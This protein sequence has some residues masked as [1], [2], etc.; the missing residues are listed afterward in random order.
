[1]LQLGPSGQWVAAHLKLRPAAVRLNAFPQGLHCPRHQAPL[2][3]INAALLQHKITHKIT[4]NNTSI[5]LRNSIKTLPCKW[6]MLLNSAGIHLAGSSKACS[7][8]GCC[9]GGT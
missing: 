4:H 2:L 7:A 1:M 6:A 9:F 8:S 3:P 5:T